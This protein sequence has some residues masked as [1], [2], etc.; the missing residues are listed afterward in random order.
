MDIDPDLPESPRDYSSPGSDHSGVTT[1]ILPVHAQQ[2]LTDYVNRRQM[3]LSDFTQYHPVQNMSALADK[4]FNLSEGID[5]F[6]NHVQDEFSSHGRLLRV[7]SANTQGVNESNKAIGEDVTSLKH[8]VGGLTHEIGG[9][10]SD[11]DMLR[12][13][14]RTIREETQSSLQ[15]LKQLMMTIALQGQRH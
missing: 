14:M 5:R 13:E 7:V 8:D 11:I 9:L 15:E 2:E 3:F 1:E 10:K 4:V 6:K 12:S